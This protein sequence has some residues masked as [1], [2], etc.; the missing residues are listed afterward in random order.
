MSNTAPAIMKFNASSP[1]VQKL[2]KQMNNPF[3]TWFYMLAKLPS[4]LWWGGRIKSVTLEKCAV[5]IPYTWRGTNPYKSTYFAALS[6]AA[7][8]STGTLAS[9]VLAGFKEKTSMYVVDFHATFSKKATG[10]ITF[11]CEDGELITGVVERAVATGEGQKV[12]MISIGRNEGGLEMAR[13]EITWSFKVKS[14][15]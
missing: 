4:M 3:L 10:K 8:L 12:Q 13:V 6:G 2:L 9:L 15:E 7:E 11:T 5:T 14:K 1:R